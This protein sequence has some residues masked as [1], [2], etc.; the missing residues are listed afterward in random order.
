MAS[1]HALTGAAAPCALRSDSDPISHPLLRRPPLPDLSVRIE[2]P[3]SM[4]RD[5]FTL[6]VIAIVALHV[7][8]IIGF[9]VLQ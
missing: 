3:H 5:V 8:I 6:L 7:A 4:A 1:R 2:P 9:E